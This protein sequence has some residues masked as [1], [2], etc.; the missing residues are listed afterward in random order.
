MPSEK[1]V[2][3]INI[4]VDDDDRRATEQAIALAEEGLSVGRIEDC[5]D[6]LGIADAAMERLRRRI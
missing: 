6:Q 5:L 4:K 3:Q 2:H 1:K